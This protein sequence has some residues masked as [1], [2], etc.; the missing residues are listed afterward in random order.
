[1]EYDFK[2]DAEEV[3][4]LAPGSWERPVLFDLAKLTEECGEVAEC[5]TKSKKTKED[6][7]EEL[8]DIMIVVAM[9]A[10]KNNIDLDKAYSRK[11]KMRI[12]KMVEKYHSGIYP[13]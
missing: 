5:F 4:R 12:D 3:F 10:R 1:M 9:I 8:A 2:K 13:T 6:L 7:E 11:K